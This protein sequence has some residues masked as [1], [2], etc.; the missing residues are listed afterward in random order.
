MGEAVTFDEALRRELATALDRKTRVTFP[1]SKYRDDPVA[2]FREVLGVEPWAKQIE[3]IESIRDHKRVTVRSGHKVSKSH[4]AC[5][6][7]LWFYCSFED[8]RVAMTST[9][10]RQVTDVLWRQ[11]SMMFRRA[12]VCIDC[13]K[14]NEGKDI[15]DETRIVAPCPHSAIIDGKLAETP[16]TG[17]RSENFR[18]IKGF[19]AGEAE[20]M[21]G[22]SA[23][24]LL[25]IV[26]EASGIRAEIFEAIEGN[27][28]GGARIAMFSNPTKTSG[29]FYDSHNSKSDFYRC[30][31]VSSEDTPNVQYG[32]DDPRAIPG[33][34]S[35]EW[36]DEKEK[37]WGKDSPMYKVRVKGDFC[38]LEEGK[39]F[40][41]DMI[42]E[43][44]NRDITGEGR[45]YIGLDVAGS[46]PMADEIIWTPRRGLEAFEQHARRGMSKVAMLAETISVCKR[47]KHRREVPVVVMD[48][49]GKEGSE[50][51][52]VFTAYVATTPSPEFELVGVRSSDKAHRTPIVYDRMRDELANVLLEWFKSGGSIHADARLARELHVLE[53]RE[54]TDGKVKITPKKEIKKE[55]GRSPDRYD[56][57]ALSTWE[58]LSLR[59]GEAK[60]AETHRRDFASPKMDPY[61]GAKQWE[62]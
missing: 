11:L 5:G 19:T 62:R 33:L 55:I 43:A 40:S 46:G 29:E 59:K 12:G 16:G 2:F 13:K 39:I 50:A 49:D 24:N 25:Y 9:T 53:W 23:P 7:A 44:E 45:L 4:T 32:D 30:I 14:E 26:D 27:R 61:A 31:H 37:E 20:A 10:A 47:Y 58:P 57:L 36:V 22:T 18:E 35:R 52:G 38:E 56:S 21:A 6:V 41:V 48:R 34:A 3:I 42:A 28:A 54:K 51:F 8:A 15:D 1:S 60:R 17:L